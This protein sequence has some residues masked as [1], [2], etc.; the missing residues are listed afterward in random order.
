MSG[1]FTR[2]LCAELPSEVSTMMIFLKKSYEESCV[3]DENAPL[4][5]LF[6]YNL[7]ESCFINIDSS[8]VFICPGMDLR[9]STGGGGGRDFK[10]NT[11]NAFPPPPSPA[12][13]GN[14]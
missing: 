11:V 14:S 10:V 13:V 8:H 2:A 4:D 5:V 7:A 12:P 1:F 9:I 3:R 6:V